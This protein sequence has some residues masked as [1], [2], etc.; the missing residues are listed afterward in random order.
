MALFLSTTINRI[1]KKGRVSIPSGFRAT[2]RA[3]NTNEIVLFRSTSQIAI[4]GVSLSKIE[5]LSSQI[6]HFDFLS[7]EQ[8]DLATV[9]F[10]ESIQ[11]SFDND[12]RVTLPKELIDFAEL[13]DDVAFVGLGSKFQI[14][15]PN[16]LEQ[17]KTAARKNV[18]DNNLTIPTNMI[19]KGDTT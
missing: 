5:Q 16:K 8:D 7:D 4:E 3:E 11:L 14:W 2:L 19:T 10:A 6:D 15:S 13:E 12:G 1:D 17:R 18:K 9:L